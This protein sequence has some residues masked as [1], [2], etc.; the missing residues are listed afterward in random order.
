M[1]VQVFH[2]TVLDTKVLIAW[3]GR[4]AVLS[5]RGTSSLANVL[6]DLRCTASSSIHTAAFF[7]QVLFGTELV[8]TRQQNRCP[9][10]VGAWLRTRIISSIHEYIL[11]RHTFLRRRSILGVLS[12]TQP[13][14]TALLT[15]HGGR[16]TYRYRGACGWAR[17]PW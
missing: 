5:F 17:G 12:P 6:S 16:R 10:D 14:K 13:D 7:I 8:I 1:A 11:I 9:V 4:T 2:E 15:G 3:N